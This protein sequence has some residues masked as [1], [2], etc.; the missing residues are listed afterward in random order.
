MKTSSVFLSRSSA[1][2]LM[3]FAAIS[4]SGCV[5]DELALDDTKSITPYGG[6]DAYPISVV[7]GPITL[8]VDSSQGT[9]QPS[10]I[11]AVQGF[12]TQA[13]AAGV[14]PI[15]ISRPNGGGASARV[16]SEIAAIITQQGI[17]RNMVRVAT[18]SGSST[19]AVV[20]SYVS[21]YAATKP[22]GEWPDD[23]SET[24]TNQH[25]ASHGCAVQ[26]NIAAMVA[27]PATLIVPATK[28]PVYGSTRTTA[29]RTLD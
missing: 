23:L 15:T 22:C 5:R 20:L 13:A 17:S 25:F 19:S 8:E 3:C 2:A 11:N 1:L 27:N 14:T 21:T 16:A 9:L 26:A 7:K 28:T 6:S 4:L 24:E 29:I 12:V 18:H 10:Q